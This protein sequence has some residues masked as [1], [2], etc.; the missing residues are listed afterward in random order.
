ML[1][2]NRLAYQACKRCG[3]GKCEADRTE[4]S[5]LRTDSKTVRLSAMLLILRDSQVGPISS[6]PISGTLT[7]SD[8]SHWHL[9]KSLSC[10]K[11]AGQSTICPTRWKK[12]TTSK[13]DN[14]MLQASSNSRSTS[15]PASLQ[16]SALR[17]WGFRV[18]G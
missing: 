13:F 8:A 5:H 10:R 2:W 1:S 7:T 12:Q 16:G 15:R 11:T 6:P 18:W 3:H 9:F 14:G 4:V 17:A